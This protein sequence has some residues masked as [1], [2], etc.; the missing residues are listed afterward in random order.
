ME[1]R[2][3]SILNHTY[4]EPSGWE[5]LFWFCHAI[6][7]VFPFLLIQVSR[8]A[9]LLGQIIQFQLGKID[10]SRNKDAGYSGIQLPRASILIYSIQC[11]IVPNR[12]SRKRDN[13]CLFTRIMG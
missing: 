6:R 9:R 11:R 7:F 10:F 4:P 5:K 2:K 13:V 12:Q 8:L 1:K 3:N